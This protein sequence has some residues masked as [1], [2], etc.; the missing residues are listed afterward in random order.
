MVCDIYG[1][2]LPD[3]IRIIYSGSSTHIYPSWGLYGLHGPHMFA[4]YNLHDL[5]MCST[6]GICMIDQVYL[7][8]NI[9]ISMSAKNNRL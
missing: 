8:R 3:E 1:Q 6:G 2:Y 4:V 9:N 5:H 7:V